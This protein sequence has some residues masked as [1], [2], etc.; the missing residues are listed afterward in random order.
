MDCSELL[1]NPQED[2]MEIRITVVVAVKD[3]AAVECVSSLKAQ[4]YD[5]PFEIILVEGGNRSQARNTGIAL[6]N[7]SLIAF[8]DADCEA[9]IDWLAKL[10]A[11]LPDD[12]VTAG[13]G[14]V[15]SSKSSSDHTERAIDGAFSISL[16]SLGSP[17]LISIPTSRKSCARALSSHNSIFKRCVLA[18]VGGFDE[19]FQL[20]EDTD[21][22]AR[23]R[24]K[25]YKLVLDQDIYVYHKKRGTLIAFAHQFFVYGLGRMRSMLTRRGCVDERIT[26]L[27]LMAV[28]LASVGLAKPIIFLSAL[29]AYFVIVLGGS[30][31]GAK[32][33]RASGLI[34]EIVICL[35][36]E[37]LSYLLGMIYGIFLGPWKN[38]QSSP[39]M[40]IHRYVILNRTIEDEQIL[41]LE[42][43]R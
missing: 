12:Q 39:T 36:L 42:Y 38:P 10:S 14:G 37:H 26:G 11:S 25:G 1:S 43:P 4:S 15:S 17:S 34:P 22:C 8:T 32:R 41:T 27:F 21:I 40:K 35:L 16:G 31:I 28:L 29:S 30:I 2:A 24:Q 19:R 3:T 5:R 7:A 9:T 33:I 18:E 23:L 13:V 6:S 20:N